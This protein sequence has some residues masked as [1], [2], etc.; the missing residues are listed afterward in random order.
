MNK[1][2]RWAFLQKEDPRAE[3]QKAAE[4]KKRQ[5]AEVGQ[6]NIREMHARLDKVPQEQKDAILRYYERTYS[7]FKPSEVGGY[8]EEIFQSFLHHPPK[9]SIIPHCKIVLDD[10][11]QEI[12]NIL[13]ILHYRIF[14]Q[15]FFHHLYP[16]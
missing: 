12:I 3:A 4:I 14:F 6:T 16:G 7:E 2:G 9:Y 11:F 1:E 5:D 8:N 15:R 13:S 10:I